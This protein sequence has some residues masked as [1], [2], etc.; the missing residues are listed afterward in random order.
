MLLLTI[1]AIGQAG[2]P[3]IIIYG[4]SYFGAVEC[5]DLQGCP[6]DKHSS[7]GGNCVVLVNGC[8]DTT[9][10]DNIEDNF[11]SETLVQV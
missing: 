10:F 7:T 11:W 3:H 4:L 6:C 1:I 5:H 2:I 8:C 9:Q